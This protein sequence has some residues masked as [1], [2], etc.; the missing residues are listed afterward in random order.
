[1]N[2]IVD[3]DTVKQILLEEFPD[4]GRL[5]TPVLAALLE[6]ISVSPVKPEGLKIDANVDWPSIISTAKGLIEAIGA[7]LVVWTEVRKLKAPKTESEAIEAVINDKRTQKIANSLGEKKLRALTR[8][9]L[10][11]KG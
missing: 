3:K 1:M 2:E 6:G 8:K 10:E 5:S 11:K 9:I 4:A 7:L